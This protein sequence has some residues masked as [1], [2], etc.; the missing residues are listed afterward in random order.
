[1][2]G[3][4]LSM[5]EAVLFDL[6]GTIYYG[7]QIIDGANDTIKFFRKKNKKIF[8]VTN[9]STKTRKEIYEKL[10][11]MGI[12]VNLDEVLTSGYLA[13]TYALNTK[14]KDIYIF[15]SAN[16]FQEFRD[17]GVLVNQTETAENLL[18][19]YNPDITY[20]ELAKATRIALKAKKIIACNRERMYPGENAKLMP[21]CGAMT[22]PIEWCANRRC[23]IVLG[24]PNTFMIEF[25]VDHMKIPAASMLVIGDTYESDIEMAKCA[26]CHSILLDD[27]LNL[28]NDTLVIK[29]V[30]EVKCYFEREDR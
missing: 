21:G 18:I 12:D 17:K 27:N 1:M 6:D 2:N 16:L 7:S 3:L 26:G 24:K 29:N 30:K 19:G 23:D 13:A 14:M 10:K 9:N 28:K 5:F 4:S 11:A 22:A 15:G 20:A 8:F 25:L